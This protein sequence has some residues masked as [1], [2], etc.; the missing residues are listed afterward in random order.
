MRRRSRALTL[1]RTALP[2]RFFFPELPGEEPGLAETHE[3]GRIDEIK[4]G[5]K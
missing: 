3:E 1:N 2:W 4:H 5:P